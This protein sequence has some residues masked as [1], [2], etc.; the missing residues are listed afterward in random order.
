MILL[1][2]ILERLWRRLPRA[3][4]N[5]GQRAKK[6]SGDSF[7][8]PHRQVGEIQ[9]LNP[10]LNRCNLKSLRPTRIFVNSL[11]PFLSFISKYD[12]LGGI[13][14]FLYRRL[15]TIVFGAFFSSSGRVGQFDAQNGKMSSKSEVYEKQCHVYVFLGRLV[16]VI[17]IFGDFPFIP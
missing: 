7:S 8:M 2:S 15:K 10:W 6:C 17:V 16:V 14:C 4:V 11:L 9:F 5:W 1:F 3:L 12:F 13:K